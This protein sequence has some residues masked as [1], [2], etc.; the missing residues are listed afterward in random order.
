[1][2]ERRHDDA[3][4]PMGGS[5]QRANRRPGQ[6]L[7]GNATLITHTV[8]ACEGCCM[9]P[10][11]CAKADAYRARTAHATEADKHQQAAKS[12]GT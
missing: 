8:A 11:R 5:G 6:G 7:W 2:G 12:G 1:M 9:T 3:H 10:C 4:R